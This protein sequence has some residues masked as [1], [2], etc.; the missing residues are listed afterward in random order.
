M[1]DRDLSLL[2]DA[3]YAAGDIARKFW[4]RD[5]EVWDK[6]DG[7]GP[8]TE[9]DLAVDRMLNATLRAERPDYGWLSEETE[10][11]GE[12][13]HHEHVFI[14]D[15]IDG[16]RAFING[17][18]TF[19][20]SLAIAQN[21]KIIAGVVYLPILDLMYSAHHLGAAQVNGKPLTA[22]AKSDLKTADI[23]AAK[24]T[25]EDQHWKEP[26]AFN[27]HFRSSLA[28]RLCL[29]AEGKFDAMLS[30]RP[31]WEWD[32]AAGDLIVERAG[33]T[34]KD[35]AN[36][37]VIYNQKDPRHNGLIAAG[38]SLQSEIQKRLK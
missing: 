1:P 8:V 14:V 2:M 32:V 5:P 15:P 35:R 18:D 4:Q 21:G 6:A 16:T 25:L 29:V 3:A 23:L 34:I 24:P 26:P 19:S 22:G 20:H 17:A 10:D 7:A 37:T 38:S 33:A 11:T 31:T 28:Y 13:Q 9:A 36:E 12:R 27:R 30:L